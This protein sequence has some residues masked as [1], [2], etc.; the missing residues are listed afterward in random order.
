MTIAAPLTNYR[1]GAFDPS[2]ADV[3]AFARNELASGVKT[4]LATL[5]N[6]E[7][8][9][10]RAP[11]AQM[12]V[13]EDGRYAGSISSG[14]LERAIIE[15]ARASISRGSGG[16]VR[17]GRGSPF[18][19]V[20][21]PC[22]SG[23][24]ILFTVDASLDAISH[25]TSALHRRNPVALALRENGVSTD[26]LASGGSFIR[27]YVPPL[28]IVAAG[29]GPELTVLSHLAAAAGY[30]FCALSPD[31]STLM[32][33]A[34]SQCVRL[35]SSGSAPEIAIDPWTACVLL[36]HDREW[37]RVLAQK[38]L[39]SPAFYVGAVGSRKTHAARL[40][41]LRGAGLTDAETARI[42]API[43]LVPMTRDPSALGVSILGEIVA[44]AARLP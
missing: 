4:A 26:D 37:E 13:T 20:K 9:S 1:A 31:E 34:A 32:R 17:Y 27:R 2:G 22:G 12:A 42:S 18:I 30:H 23:V 33:C 8:S 21:L 6:I 16:V 11:G 19:D 40:E 38:F 36:F 25:A 35:Q 43:G 3:L 41:D 28:R 5:I 15:E 39:R 24:D 29:Y 10:P 44:A 14:C 7:G